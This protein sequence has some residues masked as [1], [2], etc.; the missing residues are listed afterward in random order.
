MRSQ[1]SVSGIG[2]KL[3]TRTPAELPD[4]GARRCSVSTDSDMQ[5]GRGAVCSELPIPATCTS[6]MPVLDMVDPDATIQ[7]TV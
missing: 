7:S 4:T 1:S 5:I 3:R 2:W 6:Q